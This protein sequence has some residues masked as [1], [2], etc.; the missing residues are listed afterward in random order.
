MGYQEYVFP[1]KIEG[2]TVA[3]I[4]VGQIQISNDEIIA[5]YKIKCINSF[6]KTFKINL[7]SFNNNE[8]YI[9]RI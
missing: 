7:S 8:T 1:I 9:M 2:N 6:E 5:D 4:F 3:V